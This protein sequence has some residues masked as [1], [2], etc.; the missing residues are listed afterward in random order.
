MSGAPGARRAAALVVVRVEQLLAG[1]A[2]EAEHAAAAL[3]R[4]QLA[5]R[6]AVCPPRTGVLLIRTLQQ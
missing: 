3:L 1:A 6:A 2:V 4:G 5:G